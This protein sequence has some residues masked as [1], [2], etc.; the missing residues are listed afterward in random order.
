MNEKKTQEKATLR[1]NELLKFDDTIQ[2]N[3]TTTFDLAKTISEL[4]A[5]IWGDFEGCLVAPNHLGQLNATLY[6]SNKGNG[7]VEPLIGATGRGVNVQSRIMN[8]NLRNKN[9]TFKF[10]DEVYEILADL[11]PTGMKKQINWNAL[12]SEIS[13]QTYTGNNIYM[14]V[15][16]IDVNKI[17]G[18]LYGTKDKGSHI[19]YNIQ[20]IRPLN[21]SATPTG[22]NY[23]IIIQRLNNEMVEGIAKIMG[24]MPSSGQIQMIRA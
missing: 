17:L 15:T 3:L 19:E 10:S 14:T 2:S 1:L 20:L 18:I 8:Y 23:M 5:A 24:I 12:T 11:I 6:F 4:F 7:Q 22:T 21:Q 16:G 9:R 13:E